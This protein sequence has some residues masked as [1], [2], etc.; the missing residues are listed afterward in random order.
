VLQLVTDRLRYWVSEMHV[1]G[2]RFDLAPALAREFREYDKLSP[3]FDLLLQDPVLAGVHLIAEPWDVG[4]GGYEVGNFPVNWSEWN[5]RYR[6]TVRRFWAGRPQQLGDLAT[7]LSGS[8]DLYSDDGR[9]PFAGVNVVTVHD[10]F[11][12]A[13]LVSYEHKHNEANLEDNADGSD[14]NDGWNGRAA[15]PTDDAQV[16]ELR[17]RQTR[18]L[19][20]TLLLSQGVR[21]LQAD[22]ELGRT[23][24]GNNNAYCQDTDLTWLDWELDAEGQ[25]L[26]AFTQR[27]IR[28]RAGEPVFRRRT[29]FQGRPLTGDTVKDV[30]WLNP[31]GRE[32]Q[33][34]DWATPQSCLG[35]LLVGDE[36]GDLDDG[37]RITGGS[38]LLLLN[39]TD[40]PVD[41]DLPDRLDR[42][43][44]SVVLDT[45]S[46]GQDGAPVKDAYRLIPHS[47]AVLRVEP[48]P[49]AAAVR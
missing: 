17:R 21:L 3:F 11:A 20:V 38:F 49:E 35:V 43:D 40:A 48:P 16:D 47:S 13:D 36:I 27:V 25:A 12:L 32:M 9:R 18:N 15:G 42:L 28:L 44:V 39:A 24:R 29:F 46:T 5:G 31:A 14:Q 34:D 8:A 1:D 19:L 2:F 4:A 6:E 23:Q 41:V 37:N 7:R 26:L 10:G 45:G 30:Y 22:D 33:Q